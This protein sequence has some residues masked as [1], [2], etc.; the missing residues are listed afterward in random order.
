MV[1]ATKALTLG[2]WRWA[3]CF[4]EVTSGFGDFRAEPSTYHGGCLASVS[5]Q[6]GW[7]T[8]ASLGHEPQFFPQPRF[9]PLKCNN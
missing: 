7:A 9:L 4:R 8:E 2:C 6:V 3:Q 5:G 1:V